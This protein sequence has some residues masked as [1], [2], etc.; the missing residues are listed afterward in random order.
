MFFRFDGSNATLAAFLVARSP[1]AYIGFMQNSGDSNW[2]P[3]FELDVGTPLGLCAEGPDGVFSRG[4][5]QGVAEIDCNTW[6][7]RLP[8]SRTSAKEIEKSIGPARQ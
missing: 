2:S 1:M 6:S 7:G 8:F 4:W 3:L 5:S